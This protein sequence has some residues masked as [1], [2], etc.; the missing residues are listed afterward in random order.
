[1]KILQPL[2]IEGPPRA[3]T[4]L[5]RRHA[6]G[7]AFEIR[8]DPSLTQEAIA[9]ALEHAIRRFAGEWQEAG[10]DDGTPAG[11]CPRCGEDVLIEW[12]PALQRG[13]CAVC[14]CTW[15]APRSVWRA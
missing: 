1:V 5:I 10:V 3:G 7:L 4:D 2:I 12:D 14:T 9:R 13:A 11:P 6:E 15:R 8:S